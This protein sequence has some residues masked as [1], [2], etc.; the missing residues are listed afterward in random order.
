M[1]VANDGVIIGG[2]LI[3]FLLVGLLIPQIRSDFGQSSTTVYTGEG[4]ILLQFG[5]ALKV[6]FRC[7]FGLL[8]IFPH[9]WMLEFLYLY[10]LFWPF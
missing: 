8:E 1:N 6:F 3:L 9:F 2:I 10:G 4:M 5:E 7:S